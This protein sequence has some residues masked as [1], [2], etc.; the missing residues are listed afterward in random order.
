MRLGFGC[1]LA[2]RMVDPIMQSLRDRIPEFAEMKPGDRVLDV[3]CGTGSQAFRYAKKNI[4]AIGIDLDP[5]MIQLA[6]KRAKTKGLSKVSFQAANA[7]DLPFTE[8]LF[9]YVSICLALHEKNRIER[10]TIIS[11]IAY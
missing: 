10:D 9:D 7:L 11:E 6:E 4:N 8:N 1:Y 5:R 3:C 2:C